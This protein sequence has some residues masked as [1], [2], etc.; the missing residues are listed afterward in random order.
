M[1]KAL[2]LALA[3]VRAGCGDFIDEDGDTSFRQV[4]EG[5]QSLGDRVAEM[6]DALERDAG[7]EAVPWRELG[8]A[9]PRDVSG[10]DGYASTVTT[11]STGTAR[12][13]PSP[14][15]SS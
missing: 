2:T 4:A 3:L 8:E 10:A 6:G 9:I 11:R 13:F 1:K 5:L 14:T 12:A 7:T 15:A